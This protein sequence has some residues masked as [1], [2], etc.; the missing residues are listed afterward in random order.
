MNLAVIPF[1]DWKKCER[2][3][4]CTRDAHLI[5][6]F[7]KHPLVTKMLVINRPV[8]LSEIV[9]F[10]RNW[11]V[12]QGS[13]LIRK[14]NL[15]ISQIDE[16][17]FSLD[18]LAQQIIRPVLMRR[19]WTPYIFGQDKIVSMVSFTLKYLNMHQCYTL[20]ISAPLFVPMVRQLLPDV[21]ISDA[22]DNLLKHEFY[23][24]TPRLEQ[25][26]QFCQEHSDL[27]IANSRETTSWLARKRPD[28]VCI[29][30][31]V[32]VN[33]FNA[34]VSY[35]LP[36]DMQSVE[37]PIVGYAGKMQEMFDVTLMQRIITK[38]PE[39]NFVFIGQILNRQWVKCLWRYPNVFYLGNKHY[40][41]LPQYLAAF[42]VCIIPYSKQR[43]HGGDPIKFYEYLAIGKPVVTTPI[44]DVVRYQNYPQVR[45][46][47]TDAEFIKGLNF[48]LKTIRQGDSIKIRPLPMQS[49]WKAKAD[50]IIQKAVALMKDRKRELNNF[51]L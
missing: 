47:E 38:M 5:Q 23:R 35:A 15:C 33:I 20:F 8:S 24:N 21:F 4:F 13:C 1:H 14:R 12:L 29:P 46:G 50:L 30:N 7:G 28:S 3:G 27:L 36:P 49:S 41:Q 40:S 25:Y 51:S 37:R 32:N 26:Y 34:N 43:Q 9:L 17:I 45:I 44:G 2:E 11:R 19:N 48:F 42:D 22:Q 10:R 18:I 39:V 31:G 16:R 6:E